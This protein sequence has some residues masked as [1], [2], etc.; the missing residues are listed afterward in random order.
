MLNFRNGDIEFP[1]PNSVAQ[2]WVRG[3]PEVKRKKKFWQTNCANAIVEIG[4]IFFVTIV[5]MT[6]PKM[7]G[8][9]VVRNLGRVKKKRL[10]S[11]YFYNKSH[12]ISYY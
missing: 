1:V 5:A 10:R 8:K 11:Q 7:G 4:K 2:V 12:V 6:L 3:V 9:N